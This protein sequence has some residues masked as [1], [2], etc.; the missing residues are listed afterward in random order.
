VV[1]ARSERCYAI[2]SDSA[3]IVQQYFGITAAKVHV[4]SLGVDTTLFR[5]VPR[6]EVAS[7]RDEQRSALRFG[8]A[9]VVCVYTGRFGRDKNPL[10]LADAIAKLHGEGK[11]FRAL[12]VGDGEQAAQIRMRPGCYV[13]AFVLSRDLPKFYWASDIGVWP[14]Q[15]STSQLDAAACGLPVIIGDRANV[16]DRID[17]NGAT[18][19]EDSVEDLARVIESM[20]DPAVRRRLGDAGARKMQQSYSWDAIARRRLR[21]YENSLREVTR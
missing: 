12:F 5:S 1:N 2:S 18:Y 13:Q 4:C 21:D 14:K 17:G 9:D 15:E 16:L 20:A 19:R 7:V 3:E 11:P 10:L 8:P 6:D